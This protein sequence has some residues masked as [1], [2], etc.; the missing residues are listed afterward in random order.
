MGFLA[1]SAIRA[2]LEG[3]TFVVAYNGSPRSAEPGNVVVMR[4]R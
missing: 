1:Q 2:D 3:N 4:L